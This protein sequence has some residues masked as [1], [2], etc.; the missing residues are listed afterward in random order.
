MREKVGEG[1]D[2]PDLMFHEAK[3]KPRGMYDADELRSRAHARHSTPC[4]RSVWGQ[5]GQKQI[6][7]RPRPGMHPPNMGRFP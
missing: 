3:G 1:G 4:L 6:A 7:G 2:D 5:G